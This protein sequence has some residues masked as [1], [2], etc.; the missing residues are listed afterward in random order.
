MLG[1]D[2]VSGTPK[3][4]SRQIGEPVLRVE[5]LASPGRFKNVSFELRAGEVLGVAGLVGAGRGEVA[6]A[7]F[8]LDEAATGKIVVHGRELPPR[9]VSAAVAA[10]A[11]LR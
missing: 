8:G 5:N 9:P 7:V 3:H 1:R 6:Q 4:L 10:G 2:V 11:G